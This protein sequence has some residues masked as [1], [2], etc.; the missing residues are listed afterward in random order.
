MQFLLII[1]V[2]TIGEITEKELIT[3][4]TNQ[5]HFYGAV[6]DVWVKPNNEL[7]ISDVK[8]TAKK[9]LIGLKHINMIMLK[10]INPN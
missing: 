10:D 6:D 3:R 9:N 5:F 2:W 4:S 8:A 1:P 7:I